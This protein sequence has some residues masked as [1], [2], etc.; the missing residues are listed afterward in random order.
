MED[1]ARVFV[2]SI[3]GTVS[4][5]FLVA[6]GVQLIRYAKK[7]SPGAQV[8]GATFM[9][10]SFGNIRDPSNELIQEAKQLK[11][12]EEDDSGDP[13]GFKGSGKMKK[14]ACSTQMRLSTRCNGKFLVSRLL[15]SQ[16]P[17]H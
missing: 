11:R 14:P 6:L 3:F 4:L 7:G 9:L 13:P 12:R 15:L 1:V 8:L 16:E 10:L 17:R 5:T 2:Q